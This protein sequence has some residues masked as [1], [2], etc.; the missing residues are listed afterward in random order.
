M[1]LWKVC[2]LGVSILLLTAACAGGRRAAQAPAGDTTPSPTASLDEAASPSGTTGGTLVRLWADPPTLD[3]HLTT[4]AT[5]AAII[6]EVFGGLVTI[7]PEL[8]VVGDLA[9]S[10]DKSED[11]TSYT[12][13]LR[14]NARFHD[15]KPVT[16]EDVKW[17]IERASD[18][19]TQS[20]VTDQYLGDIVGVKEKLNAEATEVRG[21]QVLD[22][23]TLR[24]DI[25]APKSYFLAKLTYPTAFVVDR[26]QVE[27]DPR[28]FRHPNATGPF[29]LAKYEL[30]VSLELERNDFYH[31]GPPLLAGVNF[32]LGGGTG[33]LMYQNDEIHITG[34]GLADLDRLLD[35]S[36][37]LNAEI[38]QAPPSFSTQY[39][40]MNVN[41]PPFD[42]PK[43]RQALNYAIDREEIANVV[44]GDLVVPANG[45]LP[46]GFP[47]YD[48]TIQGYEYDPVKARE[49]LAESKYGGEDIPLII[50]TTP[51]S[52]GANVG[53]DTQ[54]IQEMWR[55]NLGIEV[56]T[57]QTE[58]AVYLQDLHSRIF[59]MFEIG[60]IAD[61]P[62]PENF[63]DLL[64]H[65]GS[66][67]NHT[68]CCSNPRVD[69]LLEQARVGP[70]EQRYEL[71]H[72]V[73]RLIL[74][75]APWIPLWNSGEQYILVKPNVKDY[76]QSPLIIPRL[77]Y[78]YI[79]EE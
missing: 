23:H 1:M 67:N 15:G 53:L 62:D 41:E 48:P 9:E 37:S 69:Q 26:Q 49:L 71:Y 12:F 59:Q 33:M 7:D 63:L 17:S 27:S 8:N 55:Q 6:V 11:G 31:L 68:G 61:Y 25:D 43:V 2:I 18:P 34:V 21:V 10:W 44:L 52:F 75:E 30:G 38:R 64:F 45:I 57:Q 19:E 35:P 20:L 51:G 28:W 74:E 66:S 24:I 5:S 22:S 29:K 16:A 56:E 47:G 58:F 42:D 32:L 65:S 39:I 70:D 13:H 36:D 77:R 78:V 60:W 72:E 79:T 3:P 46:P 40:G 73:E 14:E 4:D 76:Y 50:L 54:V